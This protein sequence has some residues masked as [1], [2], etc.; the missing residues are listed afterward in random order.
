LR[1]DQPGVKLYREQL[2]KYFPRTSRTAT[3]SPAYVAGMLFAEGA[4]RA[5]AISPARART[6]LESL[7][8]FDTRGSCRRSRSGRTRH[9]EAG[10]LGPVENGRFKPLSDWLKSEP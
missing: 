1:A 2:Q 7:K 6:A 5:G 9:P 10:I 4:K 8:G 3:R